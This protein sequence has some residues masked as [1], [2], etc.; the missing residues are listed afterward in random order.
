MG[1]LVGA[2]LKGS[3]GRSLT[4][5]DRVPVPKH[6][7]GHQHRRRLSKDHRARTEILQDGPSPPPIPIPW[8]IPPMSMLCDP[9]AIAAE[10]VALIEDI[11]PAWSIVIVEDGM[12]M[13][14]DM[15]LESIFI[16]IAGSCRLLRASPWFHRAVSLYEAKPRALEPQ[17]IYLL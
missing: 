2:D 17:I 10:A 8:S 3:C 7:Q 6:L 16:V 9:D 13:L 5:V 14:I 12:L 1:T 4:S 11:W 15:L